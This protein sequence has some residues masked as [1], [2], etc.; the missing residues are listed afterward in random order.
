MPERT[1][2]IDRYV[3]KR[4]RLRRSLLGM[5]QER[6]G[7]CL[8]VTFQQVQKYEGGAN[9]IGASRLYDIAGVLGVPITYFFEDYDEQEN[10]PGTGY[11]QVYGLA[12][13]STEFIFDAPEAVQPVGSSNSS[14]PVNTRETFEL[15]RA[16]NRI[17]DP[18][19]RRRLFDL[20]KALAEINYIEDETTR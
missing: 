13:G 6:L 1:H 16:F 17:T 8:G 15:V 19:V 3:G 2:P 14:T 12:E 10:V 18:I 20:A 9:R 11:N 7:E 4:V 5:S